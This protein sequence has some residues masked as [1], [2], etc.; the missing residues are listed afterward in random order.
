MEKSIQIESRQVM[1]GVTEAA[2][3][4]NVSRQHVWRVASGKKKSARVMSAL[5]SRG[6]HPGTKA[7]VKILKGEK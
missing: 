5:V 4:L 2:R 7:A 3:D 6:F 1:R